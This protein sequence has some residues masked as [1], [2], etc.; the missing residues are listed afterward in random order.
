M[1]ILT[2]IT[3]LHSFYPHSYLIHNSETGETAAVDT[4]DATAYK[5][6]L[7][8]RGWTLTH[9]LNT[10]HHGDHVGGNSE[11][12]TNGV[13]VYG[14]AND[15]NIPGMDHPLLSTL[16]SFSE[17][18]DYIIRTLDYCDLKSKIVNLCYLFP[19]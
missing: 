4:P 8:K 15:G 7:E 14:P 1:L 6:E 16:I 18:D 13:K 17:I 3:T 19:N 11:L 5:Q 10:H 2:Y 9:I 12:K